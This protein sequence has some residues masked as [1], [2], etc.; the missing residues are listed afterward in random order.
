L[1]GK[2]E[3][4][5]MPINDNKKDLRAW[6]ITFVTHNT[7]CSER[8]RKHNIKLGTPVIFSTEQEIE[9]T[10]W[11]LQI[12]QENNLKIL[13]YNICRDHLH[14]ILV[15]EEVE[16]DNIIRKIKSKSTYLYKI[17]HK[18][19]KE[20]HIWAQK[21]NYK[22]IKNDEALEDM[23]NYVINNRIKHELPPN[24]GFKPLVDNLLC[25]AEEAFSQ[26]ERT[27]QCI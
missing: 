11:I 4:L 23:Y 26:N 25:T 24:K 1:L 12:K 3:R 18:I 10:K 2:K 27:K 17:N 21:Y 9:I 20:L 13:A 7:R 16:R 14:M 19:S 8:M 6:L 22:H 15:C 5:N